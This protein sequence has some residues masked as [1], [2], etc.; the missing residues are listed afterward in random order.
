VGGGGGASRTRPCRCDHP[1]SLTAHPQPDARRQRARRGACSVRVRRC[2]GG[3]GCAAVPSPLART[4]A[5]PPI[6][7]TASAAV[8]PSPR[9]PCTN[10]KLK[11][12]RVR[13]FQNTPAV[14]SPR[15]AARAVRSKRLS[16]AVV[17]RLCARKRMQCA[18]A[19]H[20]ACYRVCARDGDAERSHGARTTCAVCVGSR[21]APV[22]RA[23][24]PLSL[25]PLS[26]HRGPSWPRRR[27]RPCRAA[28]APPPSGP[29]ATPCR[30]PWPRPARA[31]RGGGT[32]ISE[33]S[34]DR[35][36]RGAPPPGHAGARPVPTR[37]PPRRIPD[38]ASPSAPRGAL[39]G[40][41]AGAR[42]CGPGPPVPPSP[43][44]NPRS[45][46]P[47]GALVGYSWA[48]RA[49]R[50]HPARENQC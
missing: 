41:Y 6:L 50:P 12:L 33:G 29:S 38:P 21:A 42:A 14:P 30:G 8:F 2:C 19:C 28:A 24:V 9:A 44:K 48:G 26:L 7:S 15:A 10:S 32:G 39:P 45:R 46:K 35:L 22:P 43:E 18:A 36:G 47:L 20:T 23:I 5:P 37:P 49:P 25:H 34:G 27:Q 17:V 31:G 40:R 3:R 1:P 16:A 11:H 4:A 13:S